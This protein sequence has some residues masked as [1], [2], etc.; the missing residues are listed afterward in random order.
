[1]SHYKKFKL[2]GV[3][4]ATLLACDKDLQQKE[5]ASRKNKKERALTDRISAIT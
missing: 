2:E 1:M 3:I 5:K 4:P